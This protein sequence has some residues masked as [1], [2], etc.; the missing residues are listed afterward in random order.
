MAKATAGRGGRK[1]HIILRHG[2][3]V[4]DVRWSPS[5]ERL[6]S[7]D[8]RGW[9]RVWTPWRPAPDREIDCAPR[10]A[11]LGGLAWLDEERLV[12]A[13]D[14]ELLLCRIDRPAPL[15][16]LALPRPL[17]APRVAASRDGRWVAVQGSTGGGHGVHLYAAE[18]GILLEERGFR[19]GV[20]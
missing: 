2:A 15:L 18:G 13:G 16:R 19:N 7:T 20:A 8:W 1:E 6:A 17:P 5:G 9:L 10:G 11:R 4:G 14:E 3:Y 12:V